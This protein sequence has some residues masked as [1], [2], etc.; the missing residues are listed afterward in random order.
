[1]EKINVSLIRNRKTGK[2]VA[3]IEPQEIDQNR[4]EK[5]D[6]HTFKILTAKEVEEAQQIYQENE[7]LKKYN[8]ELFQQLKKK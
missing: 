5:I 8:A 3:K 4:Y 7:R 6:T 2:F 1:M